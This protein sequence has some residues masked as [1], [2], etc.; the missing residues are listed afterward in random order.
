MLKKIKFTI[1]LVVSTIMAI[2]LALAGFFSL[3]F[4][5][6]KD[7]LTD[8]SELKMIIV[9]VSVVLAYHPFLLFCIQRLL[10]EHFLETNSLVKQTSDEIGMLKE[11]VPYDRLDDIERRHGERK[12]SKM[13]EMWIISNTLQEAN[14]DENM[15]YAIYE[16]ITAHSVD[17]YYVLPYGGNS[18]R[19]IAALTTQLNIIHNRRRKK[20]TGHIYYRYDKVVA[21]MIASEY[22]D[23]VLY[24]D[25]DR[26]R[27]PCVV[28][29][30]EA[31]EGF[32]CFS[33]IKQN[34]AYYYDKI[35]REKV[36][37]MREY[38]R[39]CDYDVIKIGD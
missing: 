24:V 9:F 25:C 21:N 28:G 29:R 22:F 39:N 33:H 7:Y 14:N 19:E 1:E 26:E 13:C 15:L 23:I 31:C 2:I 17:Y 12:T 5:V 27:N 36:L 37:A 11:T 10:K 18:E 20:Q 34:N 35:E 4:D 16:N 8:K 32:Q 3:F 38:H 30:F 6:T